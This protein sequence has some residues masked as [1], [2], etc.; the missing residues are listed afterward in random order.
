[1]EWFHFQITIYRETRARWNIGRLERFDSPRKFPR[2]EDL[3]S[4]FVCPAVVRYDRSM[5][6]FL[7]F[8]ILVLSAG[9]GGQQ[10]Q[11]VCVVDQGGRN[12]ALWVNS[13]FG[14]EEAERVQNM[15]VNELVVY[16]GLVDMR[17]GTPV[18]KMIRPPDSGDVLPTVPFLGLQV[19]NAV[20]GKKEAEFLSRVLQSSLD[21]GGEKLILDLRELPEGISDF[22]A[23]LKEISERRVIPLLSRQQLSEKEGLA[24]AVA[25][26]EIVLPL[27]GSAGPG[28]RGMNGQRN[29]S[30]K[31]NLA[32]LRSSGIRIRV[33]IGLKPLS[34]PRFP[35][36]GG[37]LNQ[38][39]EDLAKSVPATGLDRAFVFRKSCLWGRKKWKAGDRIELR[40]MDS[41][42]LSQ[43]FN[44][45]NALI[46]P[47]ISGWDLFG[48]PPAGQTAGLSRAGLLAYMA[49]RGPAP[50][51]S[52]KVEKSGPYVTVHLINRGP[53]ISAFSKSG[54]W[55]EFSIPRGSLVVRNKGSFDSVVLGSFRS[56]SWKR[57]IADGV[58]AIR[59]YEDFIGNREELT[60]GKIILPSSRTKYRVKS[61]ILLSDGQEIFS[62]Y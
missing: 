50:E 24:T 8:L 33:G 42:R 41:A 19:G 28:F 60:T 34:E 62:S 52:I 45:S 38:L 37:S 18:L 39:S 44:E 26:G 12:L 48:F 6:R 2:Y 29:L 16:R 58:D 11:S 20:L 3:N 54:N 30:L 22:I 56:G 7:L 55:M 36:W 17:A 1:M 59:F 31:K 35:G 51:I 49:G 46:L 4:G 13:D 25:A 32:S 15:G 40:W 47:E 23:Y 53:F 21:G 27:Y 14:V 5:K 43:A 10:M 61:R 57:G 9:C